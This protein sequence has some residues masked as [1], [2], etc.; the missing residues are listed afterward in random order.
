[1]RIVYIITAATMFG[2]TIG[3]LAN[4]QPARSADHYTLEWTMNG[5]WEE[6]GQEFTTLQACREAHT[7]L[8]KEVGYF[9]RCT[10]IFT[11]R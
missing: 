7:D 4:S 11:S 9:S 2:G 10:G 8:D 6:T 5:N 1:M 3:V